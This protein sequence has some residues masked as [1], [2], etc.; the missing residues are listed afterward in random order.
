MSRRRSDGRALVSFWLLAA[1]G[2]GVWL[3]L[4]NLDGTCSY[5]VDNPACLGQIFGYGLA[6]LAGWATLLVAVLAALATLIALGRRV[7][8]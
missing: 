7:F 1:M 4:S 2:V 6:P 8:R 5:T 3:W